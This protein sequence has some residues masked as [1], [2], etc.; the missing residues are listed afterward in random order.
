MRHRMLGTFLVAAL[1]LAVLGGCANHNGRPVMFEED[2][3]KT[4]A[5]ELRIAFVGHG[6]LMFGFKEKIVHVDP[7]SREADYGKMPKADLILITHEHRDHLDP[8]V[9]VNR[10]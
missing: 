10:S 9:R 6:T 2:I 3:I 4:S 5:G 8:D 1:A 7:I